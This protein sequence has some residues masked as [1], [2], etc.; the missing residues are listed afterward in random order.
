MK[1]ANLGSYET[2]I[3]PPSILTFFNFKSG[4]NA[5]VLNGRIIGPFDDDEAFGEDDF[6]L[7]EK[8]SM[9]QYGDKMVMNYY[10]HMDV[11][12]SS[13]PSDQVYI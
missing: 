1:T 9:S 6:K 3:V 7:L 10:N 4:Q 5:V 13:K 11:K 2:S 8:F 12:K